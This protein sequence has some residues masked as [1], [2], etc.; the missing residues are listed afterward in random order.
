MDICSICQDKIKQQQTLICNHTFCKNCIQ[1]WLV[2]NKNCPICRHEITKHKYNLR[3]RY[4]A[5]SRQPY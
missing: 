5:L 3:Q 2:K 4:R 1:K